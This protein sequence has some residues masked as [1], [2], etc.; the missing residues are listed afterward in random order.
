[1]YFPISLISTIALRL[2]LS[3][4]IPCTHN[5]EA[6]SSATI[7]IKIEYNSYLPKSQPYVFPL[8]VSGNKLTPCKESPDLMKEI[9]GR[10]Y[11][12]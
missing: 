3:T 11:G 4:L 10:K 8:Q 7:V 6:L 1:V 2:S 5:Y 9:K 12:G